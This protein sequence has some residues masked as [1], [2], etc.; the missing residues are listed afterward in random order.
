M[1]DTPISCSGRLASVAGIEV[2]PDR[3][4][5]SLVE[6]GLSV[7][8]IGAPLHSRVRAAGVGSDL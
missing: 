8:R 1:R 4:E 2:V 7:K 3:L 5:V 6:G